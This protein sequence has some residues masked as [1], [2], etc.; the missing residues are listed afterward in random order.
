MSKKPSERQA[1][2]RTLLQGLAAALAVFILRPLR[3]LAAEW[4]K[5]LFGTKSFEAVLKAYGAAEAQAS[6]DITLTTPEIAENATVVPVEVDSRIPGTAEIAVFAEKNPL[7]LICRIFIPDGTLPAISL[8]LKLAETTRVR[9]VVKAGG[10]Y[11]MTA[12]EVKVVGE[13]CA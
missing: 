6:T 10:K 13:G 4:D 8:R 1:L 9:V 3:A 2:R 5:A 11:Y 12:R 7:P